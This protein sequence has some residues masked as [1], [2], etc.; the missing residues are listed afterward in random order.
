MCLRERSKSDNPIAEKKKMLLSFNMAA[1]PTEPLRKKRKID[2]ALTSAPSDPNEMSIDDL[3]LGF[4]VSGVVQTISNDGVTVILQSPAP[5]IQA[6][7][8]IA[9]LSDVFSFTN[10]L[11][12]QIRVGGTLDGLARLFC[13]FLLYNL[14]LLSLM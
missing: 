9:H 4:L 8:P 11:R 10:E 6:L 13:L 2:P 14:W 3:E 12:A 5:R 7:L 1:D